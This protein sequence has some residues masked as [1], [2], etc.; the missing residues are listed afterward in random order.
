MKVE[1][2]N[3]HHVSYLT[4]D[5]F[6]DTRTR[7]A[8]LPVGT[9]EC[10]G[11]HQ[12]LGADHIIAERIAQDVAGK[13]PALCLPTMH[14]GVSDLHSRMPGT[15]SIDSHLFAQLFESILVAAADNGL[16]HIILINCHKP[17]Y[18]PIETV[19]RKLRRTRGLL[20]AL[21]DPLEVVKDVAWEGF[22]E[23]SARTVGHGGE[24][25]ASLISYL[26]P[27]D[28]R[29][30]KLGAYPANDIHGM[31][32]VNS[33][34][35]RFGESRVS[36]FP[37]T[38]EINPDGAWTI[39]EEVSP[40]VGRQAYEKVCEFTLEFARYFKEIDNNEWQSTRSYGHE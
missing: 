40:E 5:E 16:T 37:G 21:V 9:V 1:S 27:L 24:P 14:Y 38:E 39:L 30:D 29:Y 20:T 15:F 11:P 17:N 22:K 25:L 8:L 31:K 33:I 7:I 18:A 36:V 26:Q 6:K 13:L 35:M 2:P 19:C 34:T 28:F 23:N 10:N 12:L 32:L 3:K 4:A